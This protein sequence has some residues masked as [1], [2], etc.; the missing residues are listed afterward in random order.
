MIANGDRRLTI[1][2]VQRQDDRLRVDLVLIDPHLMPI[3]R[4]HADAPSQLFLDLARS[5]SR[6]G[7]SKWKWR[8]DTDVANVVIRAR[9]STWW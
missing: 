7:G 6:C 9:A 4:H 2:V 8:G 1:R 3:I 5:A